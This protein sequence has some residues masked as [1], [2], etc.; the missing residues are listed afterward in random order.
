M[1]H[2]ISEGITITTTPEL[3]QHWESGTGRVTYDATITIT[4]HSNAP[5]KVRINLSDAIGYL[6]GT[7][8]GGN[9]A[10]PGDTLYYNIKL[11][12]ESNKEY[13]YDPAKATIGTIPA[14]LRQE[15]K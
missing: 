12:N 10:E 3:E 15:R 11:V 6:N 5:D 4:I 8:A 7:V 1:F 9:A 14:A 2:Y 13:Q